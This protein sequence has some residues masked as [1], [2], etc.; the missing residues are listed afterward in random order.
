MKGPLPILAAAAA[1][2]SP[3]R[4]PAGEPRDL[5]LGLAYYRVHELPADL[6]AASDLRT[7]PKVLDLRFARADGASAALLTAWVRAHSSAHG[8]VFVLENADTSPALRA[9]LPGGAGPAVVVLAPAASRVHA[10]IAVVVPPGAD[11]K[12]YEAL[13]AGT[14][15]EKLLSDNPEKVRYDE[16]YLEK[17]HLSDSGGIAS[18]PER[19]SPPGPLVD[20][21]L[22]RAVQIDRGLVALKRL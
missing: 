16:A 9:A 1:L 14:P 20:L 8:P 18:E 17:E 11:R 6:P 13:D 3:L 4:A 15:L 7:G 5:G 19:P 22:Q 2:L 10:D 21:V 12:A